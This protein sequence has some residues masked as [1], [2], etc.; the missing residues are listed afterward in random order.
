MNPIAWLLASH[1]AVAAPV[2]PD[3]QSP[4][5]VD[6]MVTQENIHET[7]CAP[8]WSKEV[9]PSRNWSSP[10]KQRLLRQ[11][12]PDADSRAFELDHRVPI[13]DGGCPNCVTNLWL[14]P[15]RDPHHHVC[16]FDVLPDAACKDRL[17][18]YVHRQICSGKMTLDQ[19]RAVFLGDWTKAYQSLI[20]GGH[21]ERTRLS[22][23]D[24]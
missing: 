10:I 16:Q 23:R 3:A 9:R 12:H 4:G 7:I 5:A 2:I 18:N 21:G 24:R 17:E 19:G 11:Q 22:R 6:P 8:G 1:L 15:W 14:Q 20:E 13:E